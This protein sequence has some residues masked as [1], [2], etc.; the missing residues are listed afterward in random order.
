MPF[1][2]AALLVAELAEALQLAHEQGLVHGD[3]KP[4]YILLGK[5]GQTGC[6]VWRVVVA[7]NDGLPLSLSGHA[8][9]HGAR[10]VVGAKLALLYLREVYALGVIMSH[11]GVVPFSGRYHG[12]L[13]TKIMKEKRSRRA[14]WYG[15][16]LLPSRRS[17]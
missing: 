1:R 16:F 13:R 17:A 2:E 10:S 4:A 11:D 3:L 5:D 15:R 8:G 9:V 7:G 6:C 14:K 12:V